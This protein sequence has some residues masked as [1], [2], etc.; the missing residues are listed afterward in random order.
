[1]LRIY[2]YTILLL[3]IG[4]SYAQ[5]LGYM[6]KNNWIE[7][8]THL[9]TALSSP[10]LNKR[11]SPERILNVY[12][13][14]KAIGGSYYR[15]LGRRRVL[16]LV[17]SYD[18]TGFDPQYLPLVNSVVQQAPFFKVETHMFGVSYLKYFQSS[19]RIAPI[20]PYSEIE[21]LYGLSKIS[22]NDNI[23][24]SREE[25][26]MKYLGVGAGFR[27]TIGNHIIYN[28]G[29]KVRMP[30]NVITRLLRRNLS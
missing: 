26:D 23:G 24:V 17:Y 1:M 15:V 22:P 7:L 28:L 18:V 3:I 20:G 29:M 4:T 12:H 11:N 27:N 9:S 19:S 6:G 30:F 5:P 14:N 8:N 16:G 13:L 10:T 2:I 21:L 25:F